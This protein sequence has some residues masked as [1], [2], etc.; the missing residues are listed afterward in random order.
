[1]GCSYTRNNKSVL[2]MEAFRNAGI[3]TDVID[4]VPG[5][6]LLAS[7]GSKNL[8]PGDK[9][10]PREITKEPSIRYDTETGGF[11]TLACVD[12]DFPSRAH[13]DPHESPVLHW[14]VVNIPG[15]EVQ[16]GQVKAA[17]IGAG[18]PEGSGFHRYVFLLFKQTAGKMDFSTLKH[19]PNNKAEGRRRFNARDF[20]AK[21]S[22]VLIG[23]NFVEAEYDDSVPELHKQLGVGQFAK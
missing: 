5:K 7:W 17:Y 8:Y 20:A 12:P 9:M 1:M 23:G 18:A 4:D 19:I 2:G 10:R 13:P 11:Y 22:L 3:I 14:L 15:N 16:K 6:L 21:H